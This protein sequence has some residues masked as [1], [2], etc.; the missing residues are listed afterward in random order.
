MTRQNWDDW[1]DSETGGT[2]CAC[3][4]SCAERDYQGNPARGPRAFCETDRRWIGAAIRGLPQAYAELSLRLV[5][6]GQQEER[7]SGSR[8]A[9]VP[10]DLETETFMRHVILVALTWEDAVRA[11]ASLSDPDKCPACDGEG[12]HDGAECGLCRGTG[13]IRTRD[14]ASLQRACEL[15]GGH[16]RDRTGYLDTLLSLEASQVTRPVP[17]SKRLAD[18]EPGT[19]IRI[20]SSGDAWAR[21]EMNGTD[22]GL[23]FLRLNGRARAML[24]LSLGRRRVAVPCDGCDRMTLVQREALAGGYEPVARCT[25]CPETY[26]GAQFELLMGREYSATV[27][28]QGKAS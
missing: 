25:N 3:G 16:D 11:A 26:I 6:D 5:K 28:A 13:K 2:S 15:L 10:V 17:G 9:P 8:E 20:D 4:R 12:E 18:L 7:V 24:G 22:A 21:A 1:D 27:Q 19:V 14:G 23:E